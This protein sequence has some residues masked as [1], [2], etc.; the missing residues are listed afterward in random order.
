MFLWSG[1]GPR[2][3][4]DSSAGK[5][6]TPCLWS[7]AGSTADLEEAKA[8][9]QRATLPLWLGDNFHP[10]VGVRKGSKTGDSVH[11][12]IVHVARDTLVRAIPRRTVVRQRGQTYVVGRRSCCAVEVPIEYPPSAGKGDDGANGIDRCGRNR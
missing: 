5:A 3:C 4:T 1:D 6:P 11:D 12:W 2:A 8:G 10:D 7:C 9:S